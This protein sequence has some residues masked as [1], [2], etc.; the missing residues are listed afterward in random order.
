MP[1]STADEFT[2]VPQAAEEDTEIPDA[3]PVN[4]GEVSSDGSGDGYVADKSQPNG[5]HKQEVKLED[6]FNDDDKDDEE[7]PSS[8]APTDN[9]GSSPLAALV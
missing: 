3:P 1:H 7:F 4:G 6:L 9:A 8:S 5:V 2:S